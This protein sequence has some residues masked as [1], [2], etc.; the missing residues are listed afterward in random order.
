MGRWGLLQTHVPPIITPFTWPDFW[1]V[2]LFQTKYYKFCKMF[3]LKQP[4]SDP[5]E[6]H[7]QILAHVLKW[8]IWRHFVQSSAFLLHQKD[9]QNWK[10]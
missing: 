2:T 7:A 10:R 6:L 9:K 5:W 3:S 4:L 1:I 8:Y